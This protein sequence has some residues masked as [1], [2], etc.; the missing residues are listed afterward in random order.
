ML[1]LALALIGSRVY[2]HR[3]NRGLPY[4]DSFAEGKADEWKALG[5]TWELVN[6]MMRNDSD[7]RGAKLLTGSPYWRNYSIEAD[8]DL[9]GINGDA[10]LIIRSSDEEDGV[11]AYTGYYAGVRTIDNS[12]VLGRAEHGWVEVNK[13]S[14][15][16]GGIRPAQWYHLKY[17]VRCNSNFHRHL[18]LGLHSFGPGRLEIL[19]FRRPLAQCRRSSRN[20]PG[21]G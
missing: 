12:L 4:C 18:R 9:L 13:Q 20:A 8:I 7:E 19:F 3:P 10:G 21:S 5:G 1:F 6:G 11:N 2:L 14:Q 17:S 16:H 15:G